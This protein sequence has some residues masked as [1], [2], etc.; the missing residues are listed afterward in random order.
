[1]CTLT[2][3]CSR[4]EVPLGQPLM[5]YRYT[6]YSTHSQPVLYGET[7]SRADRF[8]YSLSTRA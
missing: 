2:A 4:T 3:S 8:C 7:I 5:V 6:A 1:M